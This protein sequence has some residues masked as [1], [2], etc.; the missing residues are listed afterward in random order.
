[1]AR[2]PVYTEYN[3]DGIIR[4]N[5]LEC[6]GLQELKE[7]LV[8]LVSQ[9]DTIVSVS[10]INRYGEYVPYDYKNIVKG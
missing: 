7:T 1:M 9:G 8:Q 10:K 3:D 2:Y 6:N 4:T 5:N